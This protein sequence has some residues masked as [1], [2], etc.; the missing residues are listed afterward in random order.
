[1]GAK[2]TLDITKHDAFDFILSS[3]Y[4]VDNETLA[5]IVEDLNDYFRR[6]GDYERYLGLH[7]FQIKENDSL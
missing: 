6:N 7:N 4:K 1:M 5:K 3:L 2:S